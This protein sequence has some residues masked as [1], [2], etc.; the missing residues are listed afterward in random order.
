MEGSCRFT[1]HSIPGCFP[2]R[3]LP[4]IRPFLR[5]KIP[6]GP[7]GIYLFNERAAAW[8]ASAHLNSDSKRD[9][10]VLSGFKEFAGKLTLL[11]LLWER[12]SCSVGR[13][14]CT[15]AAPFPSEGKCHWWFAS[16]PLPTGI[17]STL[18]LFAFRFLLTFV[19]DHGL[20]VMGGLLLI[21]RMPKRACSRRCASE[22]RRS[23][24]TRPV[25]LW[26]NLI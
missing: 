22:R 14:W 20:G 17:G 8:L 13:Q 16:S 1:W 2:T 6:S 3:S 5:A 26:L 24:R 9:E 15:E 4:P 25:F 23:E 11:Q 21:W 7:T 12:R 19:S 18:A 10:Y